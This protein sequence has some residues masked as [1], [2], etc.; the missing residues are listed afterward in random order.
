MTRPK[1]FALLSQKLSG[2]CSTK[3][4]FLPTASSRSMRS[5]ASPRATTNCCSKTVDGVSSSLPAKA[6]WTGFSP[7]SPVP[8]RSSF[9][10]VQAP[11]FASARTLP[12]ASFS[13]I[14]HAR[15]AGAGARCR[16][17]AIDIKSRPFRAASPPGAASSSVPNVGQVRTTS[18]TWANR[19]S[20]T[21]RS[22]ARRPAGPP[23]AGA[24][25]AR[26]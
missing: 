16:F 6:V 13:M 14:T 5:C 9:R 11:A 3:K 15:D 12:A 18:H 7:P 23:V 17:V 10:K 24:S 20:T 4:R 22:C 8:L 2:L 26:R 1:G 25:T 19:L 21:D